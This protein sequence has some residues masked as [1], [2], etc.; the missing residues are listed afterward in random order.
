M[1][2]LL[3][4]MLAMMAALQPATAV[5]ADAFPTKPIRI[6]VPYSPGGASDQMMR[7]IAT[8]MSKTIGQTVYVENRPGAGG[9][10]GMQE[11]ARAAPDGH[12]LVAGNNGTH[13]VTP[14]VM[15]NTPY[16][17][18][19]DFTPISLVQTTPLWLVVNPAIGVDS[20]EQLI[21]LA[22]SKP[23][24]VAFASPGNAHTLAIEHLAM[25]AG[26]KFSIIPYKGPAQAL[27]D[28]IAGHVSVFFDT[29]MAVLPHVKSGKLK[30]L[31]VASDKRLPMFPNTP[32]VAELGFPGYDAVGANLLS[33]PA[34]TPPDVVA[35]LSK[36]IRRIVALPHVQKMIEDAAGVAV[37]STPQELAQ[38]QTMS[39]AKWRDVMVKGNIK[40]D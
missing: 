24:Q 19:K 32:T 29:G 37:N 35:K 12:T 25:M 22:K 1:R 6:V 20:L 3:P 15:K 13:V 30:A 18:V 5:G 27:G 9:V 23:G 14:L 34:N 8:E 38:W 33:V 21:A 31:A 11:V 40:F 26:V 7:T 16:D 36:E 10:I 17:P 39:T 28:T 2:V 4:L